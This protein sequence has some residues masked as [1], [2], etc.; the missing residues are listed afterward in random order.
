M[1]SGRGGVCGQGHER[2]VDLPQ[3]HAKFAARCA[4]ADHPHVRG[5]EAEPKSRA[6]CAAAL[7]ILAAV[8]MNLALAVNHKP[9]RYAG[10]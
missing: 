3:G 6:R 8:V 10:F 4:P 1:T 5:E 2:I 9:G 7:V